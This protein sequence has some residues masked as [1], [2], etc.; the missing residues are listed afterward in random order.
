MI[1]C[2]RMMLG[3]VNGD[4]EKRGEKERRDFALTLREVKGKKERERGKRKEGKKKEES[5]TRMHNAQC[6]MHID[7]PLFKQSGVCHSNE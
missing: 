1:N 5:Y 6:T 2:S 7:L 3:N 4:G